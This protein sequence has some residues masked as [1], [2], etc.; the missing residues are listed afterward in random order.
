MEKNVSSGNLHN[1]LQEWTV[2][3][4]KFLYK[5]INWSSSWALGQFLKSTNLFILYKYCRG[6]KLIHLL[7][8]FIIKK[9]FNEYHKS[10]QFDFTIITI[11]TYS[12]NIKHYYKNLLPYL[13]KHHVGR[14][15]EDAAKP[16]WASAQ[17]EC[18]VFTYISFVLLGRHHLSQ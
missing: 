12:F 3:P 13:E 7:I 10:K 14:D 5:G 17:P 2:V 8:K 6:A 9:Q 4:L 11:T 15:G 16:V 18:S 1:L